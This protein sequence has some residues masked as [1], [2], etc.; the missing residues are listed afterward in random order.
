MPRKYTKHKKLKKLKKKKKIKELK[1]KKIKELK[2]KKIKELK[3]KKTLKRTRKKKSIKK[4]GVWYINPYAYR[5]QRTIDE[6]EYTPPVKTAWLT[7]ETPFLPFEKSSVKITRPTDETPF[8][9]FEKSPVEQ[10]V[11]DSDDDDDNDTFYDALEGIKDIKSVI[12]RPIK[13]YIKLDENLCE[14]LPSKCKKFGKYRYYTIV[15][16]FDGA[17][18]KVIDILD[19][20]NESI[21]NDSWLSIPLNT[22]LKYEGINNK[23]EF[24][25][26]L[27]NKLFNDTEGIIND[28]NAPGY[29]YKPFKNIYMI[30]VHYTKEKSGKII[31]KNF[32]LILD[33][34]NIMINFKDG[35]I[36][37]DILYPTITITKCDI[38]KSISYNMC[39]NKDL[40]CECRTKI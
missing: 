32:T 12:E 30:S 22:F 24:I 8:P 23:S 18:F 26:Y 39:E 9:T 27:N 4:G 10:N 28:E 29:V 13:V 5:K 33:F 36:L 14:I 31:D 38:D 1:K 25:E 16:E 11:Y 34:N 6:T 7:D 37:D 19:I 17:K 2:K 3:G 40:D 21:Y 35:D 15:F 20:D